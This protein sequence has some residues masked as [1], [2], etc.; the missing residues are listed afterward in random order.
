MCSA[1]ANET[2]VDSEAKQSKQAMDVKEM[3]MEEIDPSIKRTVNDIYEKVDSYMRIVRKTTRDMVPK[4][5][6]LYIIKELQDYI[7]DKIL[8]DFLDLSNDE[9]VSIQ[10]EKFN[11]A[12]VHLM[13]SDLP[14]FTNNVHPAS[15]TIVNSNTFFSI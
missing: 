11:R 7:N 5:I 10:G 15:T 13:I 14:T 9:Y 3:E 4:A 2:K 12:F 1:E 6:T 8:M